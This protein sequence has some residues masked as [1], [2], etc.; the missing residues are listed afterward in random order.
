LPVF[1]G[2]PVLPFPPPSSILLSQ[3]LLVELLKRYSSTEAGR[4]NVEKEGA[5]AHL[6]YRGTTTKRALSGQARQDAHLRA[7]RQTALMNGPDENF[8]SW[9][10][11]RDSSPRNAKTQHRSRTWTP[12]MIKNC[13]CLHRN[14]LC[15]ASQISPFFVIGYRPELLRFSRILPTDSEQRKGI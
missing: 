8:G 6:S 14:V 3:V 9:F 15:K 12:A 2:C 5:P 7:S 11:I 10:P 4:A 1:N 13:E